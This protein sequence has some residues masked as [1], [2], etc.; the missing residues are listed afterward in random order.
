MLCEGVV[1][2]EFCGLGKSQSS[3]NLH[4]TSKIIYGLFS[5]SYDFFSEKQVTL[6]R[7]IFKL[8][9]LFFFLLCILK[10]YDFVVC[11]NSVGK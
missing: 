5:V 8:T 3:V 4:L 11:S 10:I 9:V 7:S 6:A 2:S 1:E